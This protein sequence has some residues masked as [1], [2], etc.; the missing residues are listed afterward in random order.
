MAKVIKTKKGIDIRMAGVAAKE[1]GQASQ[2]KFIG[3][4]PDD[5]Y[6]MTPKP[7]AKVGDKVEIGS[8]LFVDKKNPSF[9][10]V[11]PVSGVV[12]AINRGERRKI[13]D[14]VVENDNQ[15]TQASLP[16]VNWAG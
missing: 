15:A 2:A 5:F 10:V 1:Y 3:F 14:I 9:K 7:I 11:S 8:V 13:L 4:N 12:S 6:G 16:A